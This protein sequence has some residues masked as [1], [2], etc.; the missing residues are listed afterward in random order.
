MFKN[1]NWC[2]NVKDFLMM[3]YYVNQIQHNLRLILGQY[4]EK[5][6]FNLSYFKMT[7]KSHINYIFIFFKNL[8]SFNFLSF[9]F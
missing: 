4:I 8:S 1:N 9:K 2:C 6:I 3:N 7:S 5:C